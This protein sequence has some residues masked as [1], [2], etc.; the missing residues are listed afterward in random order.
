MKRIGII[1][2][3]EEEVI[4][5]K[6]SLLECKIIQEINY[7]YYIGKFEN[8][9]IVVVVCGI[10]KVNAAICTSKL[11]DKF[12]VDCVINTGVAGGINKKV[13][14]GDIV[15]AKELL[16]HDF[17]VT[18]FGYD[19]GIIPR[20]ETSIF[21]SNELLLNIAKESSVKFCGDK[22]TYVGRIASGDQF[23]SD[24]NMKKYIDNEFK[25]YAVEM[26]STAIAQTCYLNRVPFVIIRCISDKAD[27]TAQENYDD[28]VNEVSKKSAK[29]VLDMIKC[30]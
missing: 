2:A 29:I 25:A 13:E 24:I 12:K 11:I 1:G 16:Y 27:G 18:A 17:D 30:V 26:E 9:E 8:K 7:K 21:K 22:Q 4:E 19:K 20:M 15:I 14:I 23:A 5:I 6:N 10:G 3:M 28:F